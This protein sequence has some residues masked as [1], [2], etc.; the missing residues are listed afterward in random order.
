MQYQDLS[1]AH[2]QTWPRWYTTSGYDHG[3]I[4]T[5]HGLIEAYAHGGDCFSPFTTLR[6]VRNGKEYVR[7]WKKRYSRLYIVTLANR[8]A[9]DVLA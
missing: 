8:F 6:T 5:P 7:T 9:A 4:A 2:S 1:H 3:I